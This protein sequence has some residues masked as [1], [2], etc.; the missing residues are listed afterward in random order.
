MFKELLSHG[1]YHFCIP[2]MKG[3]TTFKMLGPCLL[4]SSEAGFYFY[5]EVHSVH[6]L[7]LSLDFSNNGKGSHVRAQTIN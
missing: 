3:L 2:Q 1:T 7:Y 5:G 6:S 4:S